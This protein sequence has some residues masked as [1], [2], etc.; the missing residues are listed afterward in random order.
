MAKLKPFPEPAESQSAS[1]PRIT[2]S[3]AAKIFLGHR[4]SAQIAPATLRKYQGFV[5]QLT[6]FADFRGYM[7]L[8]QFTSADIDLFYGGVK[9]GARAKGKWLGTLRAFF[10]FAMNRKWLPENPVSP[11]IKPPIGANRLANKAP[12]TNDE[13]ERIIG[14]CDRIGAT[15]WKSGQGPA[16]GPART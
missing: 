13:L 14:A 4:E 5:R 7:M 12:F 2:I 11:D 3:D 16:R 9:L 15:E 1:R 8:D 6:A 10:R